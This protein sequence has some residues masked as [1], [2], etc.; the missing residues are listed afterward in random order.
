LLNLN[1]NKSRQTRDTE[2]VLIKMSN[3]ERLPDVR[4]LFEQKKIRVVAS[5]AHIT[6][7]KRNARTFVNLPEKKILGQ[8]PKGA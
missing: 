4:R 3:Q 7:L 5:A 1:T 8:S 6:T 2:N